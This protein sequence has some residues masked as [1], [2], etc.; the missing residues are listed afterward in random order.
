[1]RFMFTYI[2]HELSSSFILI[3]HKITYD[4]APYDEVIF[5]KLP[6][7]DSILELWRS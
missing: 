1:M 6:R 4:V 5:G 7:G 2:R 3:R